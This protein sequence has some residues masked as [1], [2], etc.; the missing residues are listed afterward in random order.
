MTYNDYSKF[1]VEIVSNFYNELKVIDKKYYGGRVLN[2]SKFRVRLAYFFYESNRKDIRKLY[3][4]QESKP[5]D[6]HKIAANIM[7]SLLKAK[8]IKV[9]RLVPNLPLELLLANEY[10]SFYCALNIIELYKRDLGYNNYSLILPHT[11]IDEEPKER[12]Y[13]EN[14]CKALYYTKHFGIGEV[15]SYA[16]ILFLLEK[17]SD[18]FKEEKQTE[19][20]KEQEN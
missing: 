6:R 2:I 8:I 16:N 14:V 20:S 7:C 3:M 10:V 5:M 4:V 1:Y 18:R 12:S 19:N 11:Y 15:F 9:N 13:V 17:Y